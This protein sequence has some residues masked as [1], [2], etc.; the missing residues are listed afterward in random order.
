MK[1]FKV[2][3]KVQII[4]SIYQQIS[5]GE[6]GKIE[7]KYSDGYGVAIDKEWEWTDG[8]AQKKFI[9]K[10]I[11]WFRSKELKLATPE[12]PANDNQ[13]QTKNS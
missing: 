5:L 11:H 2:G 7:N 6:I 1:T 8:C 12:T 10:R 13:A 9:E 4:S 3:D